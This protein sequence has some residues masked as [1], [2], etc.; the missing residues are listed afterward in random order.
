MF[1]DLSKYNFILSNSLFTDKE[2]QKTEKEKDKIIKDLNIENGNENYKFYLKKEIEN[3]K[4]NTDLNKENYFYSFINKKRKRYFSKQKHNIYKCPSCASSSLS[5][6][7]KHIHEKH[8]KKTNLVNI[9]PSNS[10]QKEKN[11]I[12][13][14]IK[15]S[16]DK[17]ENENEKKEIMKENNSCEKIENV[18]ENDVV[19]EKEKKENEKKN[20]FECKIIKS[21]I[22]E[23]KQQEPKTDNEKIFIKVEKCIAP[24]I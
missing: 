24:P 11:I 16:P 14:T 3:E 12:L 5:K 2:N 23:K 17:T 15:I 20:I 7:Y 1:E 21:E 6:L 8:C 13:K 9:K 22:K 4:Y 10:Q 19:G 18:F